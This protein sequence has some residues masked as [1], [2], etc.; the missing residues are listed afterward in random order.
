MR[1][2]PAA[3]AEIGRSPSEQFL[4]Q[5]WNWDTNESHDTQRSRLI[6]EY[7]RS[8]SEPQEWEDAFRTDRDAPLPR[9]PTGEE[10]RIMFDP[11]RSPHIRKVAIQCHLQLGAQNVWLRT[12]YAPE[13]EDDSALSRTFLDMVNATSEDNMSDEEDAPHFILNNRSQLHFGQD[14]EKVFEVIPELIG[15]INRLEERLL[16]EQS[17]NVKMEQASLAEKVASL[18][19]GTVVQSLADCDEVHMLQV[20]AVQGYLLVAD[21][22]ALQTGL[23]KLIWYDGRGGAIRSSTIEPSEARRFRRYTELG[24]AYDCFD[25]WTQGFIDPKYRLDGEYRSVVY[26]L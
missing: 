12:H 15:H 24:R 6:R 20:Y 17:V 11:W 25:Y 26:G 3:Q 19:D 9:V 18:P 5:N 10:K 14:W 16:P 4:I 7:L 21:A 13:G 8:T 2:K 1:Q 22:E 23:F